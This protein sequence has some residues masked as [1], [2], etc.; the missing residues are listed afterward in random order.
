[1]KQLIIATVLIIS[2]TATFAKDDQYVGNCGAYH[3]MLGNHRE[4]ME[5]TRMADNISRMQMWARRLVEMA[6]TDPSGAASIGRYSCRKI[7]FRT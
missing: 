3:L 4:V 2:T 1:M 5:V 6:R 7:D